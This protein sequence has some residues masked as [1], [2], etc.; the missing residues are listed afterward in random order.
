M[1]K[2]VTLFAAALLT[3]TAA[4]AQQTAASITADKAKSVMVYSEEDEALV[5]KNGSAHHG[6]EILIETLP[7]FGN[8]PV[9]VD[10]DQNANGSYTFKKHPSLQ[11]PE[12]Y[13]VIITDSLTG[14]QFDLKKSDSYTFDVAKAMPE[15]FALEMRKTKT[16][17]TMR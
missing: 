1:K 2:I 13:T 5:Y 8:D 15:R 9:P 11:L 17:L 10:I 12:Y 3:V 6:R 14:N 7:G 16:E 4:S